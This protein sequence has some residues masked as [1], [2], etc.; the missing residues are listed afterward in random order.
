MQLVP[1]KVL[2]EL[3]VN[4]RSISFKQV[5]RIQETDQ[6]QSAYSTFIKITEDIYQDA[7]K[8]TGI[9]A[10]AMDIF[11]NHM[12]AYMKDN[13]D[14]IK[15]V[16]QGSSRLVYALADGTA[17]K[18][19]KNKAG[20]AQNHQ[21]AKVCMDPEHKYAIFPDFYGAD[22]KR[23]L[24]LNCE[25]C[26]PATTGDFKRLIGVQPKVISS[27]IEFILY[28]KL[29]DWEWKK[30]VDHYMSIDN[31]IYATFAKWLLTDE[32]EQFQA[33]RSLLDFYRQN[34]TKELMLGDVEQ[35]ENWGIT[36]RDG[37]EILVIIDAGF[38]EDIYDR[39]YK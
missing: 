13:V 8:K 16:G 14:A 1:R 30:L 15:F 19:A 20:I 12:L 36:V 5:S 21:E 27:V 37:K 6:T 18:L 26:A 17:L 22:K 39:F 29:D 33:L 32:S 23:W 4:R 35:L 9:Q 7:M 34:G 2:F 28:T 31:P 10:V 24:S 38:N 11:D 25:C 3:M